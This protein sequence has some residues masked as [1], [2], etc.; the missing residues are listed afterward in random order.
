MRDRTLWSDSGSSIFFDGGRQEEFVLPRKEYGV[1]S[2]VYGQLLVG[3][4]EE[5]LRM[6]PNVP[7][8]TQCKHPHQLPQP[9]IRPTSLYSIITYQLCKQ[10]CYKNLHYYKSRNPRRNPHILQV[11]FY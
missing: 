10:R 8:A 3:A 11:M 6:T 7:V 9:Y 1:I 4:T 2:T 5:D